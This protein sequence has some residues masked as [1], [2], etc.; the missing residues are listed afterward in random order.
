MRAS[1]SKELLL[2]LLRR[3]RRY[4]VSGFSMQPLLNAEDEVLVDP[5][6]YARRL[7]NL[8]D[9]VVARHPSQS[10]LQIIK[11]IKEVRG[12]FYLLAGDNPDP[13]QTSSSLVP[14]RLILG[15]VTSRFAA[16]T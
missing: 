9:I 4:R 12:D 7:P 1:N 14:A 10:E 2:W 11:R 13:A 16:A 15:R 3:R 6:A 5:R 8:D